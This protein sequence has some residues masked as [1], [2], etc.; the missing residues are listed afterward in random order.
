M[1]GGLIECLLVFCIMSLMVVCGG[2]AW[3]ASAATRDVEY[4]SQL[5]SQYL[6]QLRMTAVFHRETRCLCRVESNHRCQESWQKGKLAMF[7]Q[8]DQNYP[9][10]KIH[11]TFYWPSSVS[12][13]WHSNLGHNQSLCFLSR[14]S[15]N[16]QMGYFTL[17][18]LSHVRNIHVNMGGE[19]WSS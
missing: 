15:T 2:H 13:A 3:Q 7:S 17:S 5:L 1:S 6:F 10:F 12:L 11:K 4:A 8:S 9:N 14:G 19:M 18:K 16:G